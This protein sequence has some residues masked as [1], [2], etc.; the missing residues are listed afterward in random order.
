YGRLTQR[1]DQRCALRQWTLTEML[2]LSLSYTFTDHS[3][4][5][6]GVGALSLPE[7]GASAVRHTHRVQLIDSA[8]FSPQLRNEI[9]LVFKDQTSRSGSQADGPENPVDGVF[10]GGPSQSLARKEGR[11]IDVHAH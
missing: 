1:R 9:I 8:A 3:S 5:N 7:Q 10:A 11:A 6:N 4:K 2:A